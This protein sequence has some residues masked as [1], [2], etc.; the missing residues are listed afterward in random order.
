[1]YS[2]VT[3]YS[4]VIALDDRLY[5]KKNG[6]IIN[7]STLDEKW[8][9]D[10]K[11]VKLDKIRFLYV[12]RVNPEKGIYEFL[13]M[14]KNMNADASVSIIGKTKNLSTQER[15][16]TLIGNNKN[17]KFPGYVS[18]RQLLINTYDDHN[19]LVLPSYTEGQ[20]YVVDESLARRRP[21]LIFED[22]AHII[23]NR[24]GIFV[25]KRNIKSFTETTKFI[26]QNYKQIQK[27]I[28][29]NNFPLEKDMFKQI[30]E[31]I[32]N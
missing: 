17:I 4:T 29:K 27:D 22:I 32:N 30:A 24:K 21:V 18:D 1:M 16:K 20:P 6:H 12:A 7:S 3:S 14:F 8:L 31:V 15:F 10:F 28:E 5:N 9:Q 26:M 11:K 13:E 25:S 23:K 19:I 2:I